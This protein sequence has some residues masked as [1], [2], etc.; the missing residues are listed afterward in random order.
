MINVA[1]VEISAPSP[2]F[3]AVSKTSIHVVNTEL[4]MMLSTKGPF[5]QREGRMTRT[6]VNDVAW[7]TAVITEPE[8]AIIYFKNTPSPASRASHCYPAICYIKFRPSKTFEFYCPMKVAFGQRNLTTAQTCP[9]RLLRW[10]RSRT[11]GKR[12]CRW[13]E[14]VSICQMRYPTTT[15]FRP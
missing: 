13:L 2:I 15:S 6:N 9:L 10:F 12:C 1:T 5:Q 7:R 8:P 11:T 4:L 3:T 14:H